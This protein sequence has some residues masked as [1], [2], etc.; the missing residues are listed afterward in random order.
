MVGCGRA[1]ALPSPGVAG[2]G[3]PGTLRGHQSRCREGDGEWAIIEVVG[4]LADTEERA[5]GRVCRMLAE[6][7]PEPEPFDQEA[8]G[9][10]R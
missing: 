4:H 6:Q 3:Q 10:G 8:L 1:R 7:N 9:T 5:L 2:K